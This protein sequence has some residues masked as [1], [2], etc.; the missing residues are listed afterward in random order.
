MA[1]VADINE[2]KLAGNGKN[3]Y[4]ESQHCVAAVK[5]FCKAPQ[6]LLW[7]K[8]VKVK[9]NQ[10]IRAGTAI[11]TFNSDKKYEGHAAVYIDQNAQGLQVID[12]WLGQEFHPRTIYFRGQGKV[13]N[14]GEQ[15]YVVD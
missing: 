12:Q 11:A 6:T 15:F 7:K 13:S 9:N 4:G 3:Y 1:Y 8:G 10:N 2:V 5:H 14:D